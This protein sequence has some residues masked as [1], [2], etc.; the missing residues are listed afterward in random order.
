MW[1]D[2]IGRSEGKGRVDLE[3]IPGVRVVVAAVEGEEEGGIDMRVVVL[4]D[5]R[6]G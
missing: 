4:V 3:R 2:L 1:R 5:G 6:I